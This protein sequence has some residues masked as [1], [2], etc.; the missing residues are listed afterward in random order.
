MFASQER[1]RRAV[2]PLL[3][4]AFALMWP[5]FEHVAVQAPGARG[6]PISSES[7]L[8]YTFLVPLVENA[9]ARFSFWSAR[10]MAPRE[11]RSR[12]ELASERTRA[13]RA[14]SFLLI[15]FLCVGAC[16][17]MRAPSAEAPGRHAGAK[18]GFADP[19]SKAQP[20]RVD[21]AP[22]RDPIEA[23]VSAADRSAADR[24]LD[25]QR[26]PAELLRFFGVKPGQ[27]VAELAAGSGYTA[28]L[29]ARVV[30]REGRVYGQNSPFILER[31][32]EEPWSQRL[33]RPVMEP[34]IR[35]DSE[36]DAPLPPEARDLDAVLLILFYHDT[37]WFKTERDRMNE[38]VFNALRPGGVYA[39]VDHSAAPGKGVSQAQ[40]LHRIEESVLRREVEAAGFV[41]EAEADFLRNP[42]DTRDWNASPSAAGERRGTSDRFVLRFVKPEG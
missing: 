22:P 1:H 11:P 23:A 26:K 19:P 5:C 37:V 8:R 15:V 13:G 27:R 38:A 25:A 33:S 20:R 17:G 39:I 4:R 2:L 28:E 21:E 9:H 16:G 40:S 14:S 6:R 34:V 10:P 3:G 30:G 35:V 7:F 31:F 36:L 12:G 29:L 18:E 41:L 32:A 42:A 24:A